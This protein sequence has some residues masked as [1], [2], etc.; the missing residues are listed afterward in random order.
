MELNGTKFPRALFT[1]GV[2][3]YSENG[4]LGDA[5]PATAD[6]GETLLAYVVD[7]HTTYIQNEFEELTA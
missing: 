6:A 5:R 1:K 7:A 4:I 2:E 3:T